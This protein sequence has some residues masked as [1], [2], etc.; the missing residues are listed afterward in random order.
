[1]VKK[2]IYPKD[3]RQELDGGLNS[4]HERSIISNN[5]SPDCLNVDCTEGSVGT[6][7]GIKSFTLSGVGSMFYDALYTRKDNLG[8]ESMIAWAGGTM[9]V[10]AA[11]TFVTVP[12]AQSVY[13]AG[14]NVFEAQYEGYV[15]CCNGE[16]TPYKYNGT[17]RKT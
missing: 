15:F 13:T 9:R 8:T 10:Q 4:K 16:D 17:D 2:V 5:E 6:R 12:S 1:M 14:A 11:N 7:D 3:K